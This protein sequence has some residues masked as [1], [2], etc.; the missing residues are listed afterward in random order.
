MLYL[1]L[2]LTFFSLFLLIKKYSCKYTW[3]FFVMALAL[4]STIFFVVLYVSKIGN[5]MLHDYFLFKWDYALYL[6]V[7][8]LK[9]SYY[10]IVR[11][12]NI[13]IAAYLF[14]TKR[15]V[16]AY[17]LQKETHSGWRMHI[18]TAK[19]A[20]LPILYVILFDPNT[21]YSLYIYMNTSLM[22]RQGYHMILQCFTALNL[23]WIIYYLFS[24]IYSMLKFYRSVNLSVKKKQVLSLTVSMMILNLF[25]FLLIV[26]E[27]LNSIISIG[28]EYADLIGIPSQVSVPGFYYD[29]IPICMLIIVDV[30]LY[31][32]I[33][34]NVLD[35]IDIFREYRLRKSVKSLNVNLRNIFHSFKN[36]LFTINILTKQVQMDYGGE[37]GEKAVRRIAEITAESINSMARMLDSF[38][39]IDLNVEQI[40]LIDVVNQTLNKIEFGDNIKIIKKIYLPG[41]NGQRRPVPCYGN[42]GKHPDQCG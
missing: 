31:S 13:S 42:A 24:P 28:M 11:G 21:R 35:T 7:L 9:V 29:W 16:N 17:T 34:F 40:N 36:T 15:F 25:C 3:Y 33:K 18:D 22:D 41:Y 19:T 26:T 4:N 30:M 1:I 14:T 6:W 27:P 20:V 2:I 8:K 32:I 37:Q 39:E 38:K 23:A 5:Y 10:T 12:V